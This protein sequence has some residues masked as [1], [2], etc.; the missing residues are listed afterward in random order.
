MVISAISGGLGNQLFQYAA[1]RALAERLNAPLKLEKEWYRYSKDRKFQLELFN[2]QATVITSEREE[3]YLAH[4]KR[5]S[6][7][8]LMRAG[9]RLRIPGTILPLLDRRQGFDERFLTV[10]GDVYLSGNWQTERYF[11]SIADKIRQELTFK[12]KPDS[13]NRAML[14]QIAG[15]EAVMLHVRRGDYV[16]NAE[17]NV[18]HGVCGLDYYQKAV[19]LT[20]E[21]V[22]N[23]HFFIFSDD[24]EWTAANLKLDRP[25]TYVTHNTGRHDE[26]DLRLMM[27]CRHFIVA[28]SSFSWWG[29]W[30]SANP[31]K[32]VIGPKRWFATSEISSDLAPLEWTVI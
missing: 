16:K 31:S 10:D 27:H 8:V 14:D 17:T 13:E 25:S 4:L 26:E 29:A 5:A 12:S 19:V 24:P 3:D 32:Q 7:G 1:G 22:S 23:P 21:R 9:R 30:L 11:K 18:Y 20:Q 28:N 15:T 6:I 2:I